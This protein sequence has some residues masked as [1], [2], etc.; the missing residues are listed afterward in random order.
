MLKIVQNYSKL[1]KI[2]RNCSKLFEIVQNYPK[3][4]LTILSNFKFTR[5][6][7]RFCIYNGQFTK[8][9]FAASHVEDLVLYYKYLMVLNGGTLIAY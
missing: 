4:N 2:T 8:K 6:I 3:H 9:K 7:A 1:F 5:F